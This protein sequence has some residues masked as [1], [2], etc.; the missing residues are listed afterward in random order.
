[1]KEV[2]VYDAPTSSN[3]TLLPVPDPSGPETPGSGGISLNQADASPFADE[4]EE[5]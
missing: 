5:R 3:N 4:N 1:V 2:K